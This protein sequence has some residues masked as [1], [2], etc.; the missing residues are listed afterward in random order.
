MGAFAQ[1][2]ATVDSV[3]AAKPKIAAYHFTTLTPNLGVV[4]TK[5][6]RSF[7]VADL[8]G[9]IE[10]ASDG[11]GLGH[12]FLRH[13]ERT[14]VLVHVIDIAEV[15]GRSAIEDYET[16]RKE[17]GLYNEELLERPEVIALNKIEL[18]DHDEE[19]INN[20]FI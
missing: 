18:I 13:I 7:V 9:L 16:I 3:S 6:G 15:D 11:T 1:S 10:G 4:K 8:P 12:Q 2:E 19:I 20:L 17:M 14:K 5:D